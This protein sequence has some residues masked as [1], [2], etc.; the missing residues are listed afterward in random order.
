VTRAGADDEQYR[1]SMRRPKGC[2]VAL[3]RLATA[4]QPGIDFPKPSFYKPAHARAV[5]P[6]QFRLRHAMPGTAPVHSD[7]TKKGR[8]PRYQNK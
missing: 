1:V 5:G 3:S 6:A 4:S 8:T 7:S 2:T